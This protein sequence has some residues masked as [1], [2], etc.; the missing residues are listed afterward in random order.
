MRVSEAIIFLNLQILSSYKMYTYILDWQSEE[1]SFVA[2]ID[3]FEFINCVSNLV[4]LCSL[5]INVIRR[6]AQTVAYIQK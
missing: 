2:Y 3:I 6:H 5:H 1:G 4:Q